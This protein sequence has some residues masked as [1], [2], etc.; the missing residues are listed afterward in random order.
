MKQLIFTLVA[1]V[2][3]IALL[4]VSGALYVVNEIEQVVITQFGQPIGKPVTE[5]GLHFKMPFIQQ[6]N[7]FEKRMLEWDGNP[8]QIPTKDKKYIW[9]DTTARWRIIDALKFLQSVGNEMGAQARLDD[10]IDSATRDAVT[11]NNL[12]EVVR[13]TNTIIEQ[14]GEE[15]D[16]DRVGQAQE[17][18]ETISLGR[19]AL[20]RQ[21]LEEASKIVPQYGIDLIDVR[22]KRINYV[23]DVQEKVFERMISERKRAAEKYRSEGQGK[24]AEIEGRM[25][26]DLNQIRSEAYKTAETLKGKADAEATN[27]YADAYNN[28]PEFYSF[29]KT[30]DTYKNTVDDKTTI[31]LTTDS[32]YLNYLKDSSKVSR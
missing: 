32:E 2:F 3:L 4:A 13:N 23:A 18:L 25:A 30:L 5:A 10:I 9:V 29:L 12:V 1:V 8:N 11:S 16:E 26:K 14:K 6:A 31:I 20:T 21:I 7:Y 28:D 19:E 22:I 17:D 15:I 27:I 24:K